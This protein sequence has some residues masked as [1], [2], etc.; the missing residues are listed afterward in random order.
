MTK[1]PDFGQNLSAWAAFSLKSILNA[2]QNTTLG[3]IIDLVPG[4]FL[5]ILVLEKLNLVPW[6]T[7]KLRTLE[8]GFQRG[9]AALGPLGATLFKDPF[10]DRPGLPWPSLGP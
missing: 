9:V 2:P 10:L 6:Q 1:W 4:S 7:K 3:S 8:K 5:V